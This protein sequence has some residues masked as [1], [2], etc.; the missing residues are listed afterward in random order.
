MVSY[1]N[2]IACCQLM[3]VPFHPISQG[4][5]GTIFGSP[6]AISQWKSPIQK[7]ACFIMLK[8]AIF[9]FQ[10]VSILFDGT[11]CDVTISTQGQILAS[12]PYNLQV[13]ENAQV[14]ISQ[15]QQ[16]SPKSPKSQHISK[17]RNTILGNLFSKPSQAKFKS[18]EP[19]VPG[20]SSS[21]SIAVPQL[22]YLWLL[23]PL[24]LLRL[25]PCRDLTASWP[26][27]PQPVHMRHEPFRSFCTRFPLMFVLYDL[28]SCGN[29]RQNIFEYI[30]SRAAAG[31]ILSLYIYYT[32]E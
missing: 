22:W 18:Q 8:I 2:I 3:A 9:D 11:C 30:I 16:F 28:G 5:P 13:Q 12:S 26:A 14:S 20:H 23:R 27:D 1:T 19:N 6:K 7:R 29:P 25:W 31:R 17:F 4:F 32:M 21:A 10:R 24:W 15:S